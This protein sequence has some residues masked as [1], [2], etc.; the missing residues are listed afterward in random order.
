MERMIGRIAAAAL[1]LAATMVA[2]PSHAFAQSAA[3]Q[4]ANGG[5]GGKSFDKGTEARDLTTGLTLGVYSVAA[6]GVTIGGEQVGGTFSTNLGEGA[7]L[8]AGFGFN[9][10]FSAYASLDVAKQATGQDVYPSGTFGLAH[11]EIGGRANLPLNS[12]RTIPYVSASIGRRALAAKVTDEDS[13]QSGD[14]ALSGQTYSVGGGVQ[15]FLSPHVA[16]DGG[17]ELATGS[18]N[19]I[20]DVFGNDTDIPVNSST[21]WRV[22]VGVNWRP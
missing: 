13:G 1:T 2:V 22:R 9:R 8:M 12:P 14:F 6:A 16:L 18:F 15:H 11:F 21:S 17:I 20:H 4:R 10:T 19:H 5:S 3:H 7:G